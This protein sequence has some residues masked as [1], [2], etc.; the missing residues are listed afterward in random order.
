MAHPAVAS[1]PMDSI[2]PMLMEDPRVLPQLKALK[3]ALHEEMEWMVSLPDFVWKV[4]A[5]VASL[6]TH[7]F[8][9]RCLSAGHASVCIYHCRAIV[10]AEG[11]PFNLAPGCIEDNLSWLSQQ[12]EPSELNAK[13]IWCLLQDGFGMQLAV[14]IV[15]LFLEIP[16]TTLTAEQLHGIAASLR[17]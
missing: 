11:S 17:R 8:R 9:H 7:E 3:N 12:P 5:K 10:V 4:L 2:L 14:R 6:P 1:R 13:K 16:W 15:S